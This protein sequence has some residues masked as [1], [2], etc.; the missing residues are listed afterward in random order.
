MDYMLPWVANMLAVLQ[1]VNFS[2]ETTHTLD[3]RVVENA[4]VEISLECMAR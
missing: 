4:S 1:N 3:S 2:V